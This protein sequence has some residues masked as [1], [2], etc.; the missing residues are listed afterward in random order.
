MAPLG[1]KESTQ[2]CHWGETSL[3]VDAP[4][5]R[6]GR[7]TTSSYAG[8]ALW[9]TTVLPDEANGGGATVAGDC[10]GVTVAGVRLVLA[11]LL[12]RRYRVVR[13]G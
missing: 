9:G 6:R 13:R 11:A 5:A 12:Q 2:R 8:S 7:T 4:G 10:G 3:A 1:G